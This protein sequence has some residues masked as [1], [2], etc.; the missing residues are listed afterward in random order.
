MAKNRSIFRRVPDAFLRNLQWLWAGFGQGQEVRMLTP[1][2]VALAGEALVWARNYLA[3]PHPKLGRAGPVCPFALPA[4]QAGSISIAFDDAEGGSR[5]RL[6]A[7]VLR[8]AVAFSASMGSASKYFS[9]MV[10]FPRLAS[11]HFHLLDELHE[12]LKTGVMRSQVMI[13][14][15]HPLS[16]TPALWNPG[17]QI[18]R[19]PFATFV[20]R[21]MVVRDIIFVA[22][23]QR[24]FERYRSAFG[25][26]FARGLVSDEFGYA[27]AFS[28]AKER[29]GVR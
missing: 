11:D 14:A 6:R 1:S 13:S 26:L 3:E 22:H 16:E 2:Q 18:F 27:T 25:S 10:L 12:E 8:A 17:F 15:F 19:A 21:K 5:W 20:F 29:F 24:A 23:N 9:L 7:A 4:L 28:E